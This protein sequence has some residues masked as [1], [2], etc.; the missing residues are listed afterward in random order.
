MVEVL[1]GERV[2]DFGIGAEEG[3]DAELAVEVA[4]VLDFEIDAEGLAGIEVAEVEGEGFAERH[5]QLAR[6]LARSESNAQR[7][8]ELE[9][10][11][12]VCTQVP[13]QAPRTFQEALQADFA[14]G[15]A[16]IAGALD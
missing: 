6:E 10:I 11:A 15:L 3:F 2:P 4:E 13:A 14:D 8:A 12:T 16:S 5:A 1:E 9:Q 7:K